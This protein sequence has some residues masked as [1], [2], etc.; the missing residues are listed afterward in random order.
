[1]RS[2]I[3]KG[4][5]GRP[6]RTAGPT[7]GQISPSRGTVTGAIPPAARAAP[8]PLRVDWRYVGPAGQVSEGRE[9][10]RRP[11]GCP[12]EQRRPDTLNV[13]RP[14][15]V[16]SSGPLIIEDRLDSRS[17]SVVR[18]GR[19]RKAECAGRGRLVEGSQNTDFARRQGRA[20]RPNVHVLA[21]CERHRRVRTVA[22]TQAL[23]H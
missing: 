10:P 17:R 19:R 15:A 3:F 7:P 6:D 16:A 23:R 5:A 21:R 20:F 12:E 4:P 9:Q 14:R 22:G 1:M 2:L 8:G 18:A 13:A 11:T